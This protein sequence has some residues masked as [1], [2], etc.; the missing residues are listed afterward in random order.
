MT[1]PRVGG[2]DG[3]PVW[4]FLSCRVRE[5]ALAAPPGPWVMHGRPLQVLLLHVRVHAWV[6]IH[7]PMHALCCM[8]T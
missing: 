1:R 3:S 5:A 4:Q 2:H 6:A 7:S 8:L